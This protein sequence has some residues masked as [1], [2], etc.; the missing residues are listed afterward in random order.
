MQ[1]IPLAIVA[2]LAGWKIRRTRHLNRAAI[3]VAQWQRESDDLLRKLRRDDLAPR[4]YF[5]DASRVVQLK[6]ALKE[7][8]EPT[9][10]DADVAAHAFALDEEQSRRLHRLFD[11][12][13]ELRYSG[14]AN[15][16]VS[17]DR[18]REALE[19]IEFLR[20]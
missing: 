10:V 2:S 15:G 20:V 19:L 4:E 6:T 1:L 3:R 13:D 9:T 8:L 5:A 14:R 11:T 12:S 17:P 18:R 16:S 7:N